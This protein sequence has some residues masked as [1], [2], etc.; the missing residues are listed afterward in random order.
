[1]SGDTLNVGSLDP[2]QAPSPFTL[3]FRSAEAVRSLV[4]GRD[5]LRLAEA[6]IETASTSKGISSRPSC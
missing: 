3:V 2:H 6:Y 4:L 1:V 5:Q